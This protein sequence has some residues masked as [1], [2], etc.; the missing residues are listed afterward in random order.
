MDII[1]LRKDKRRTDPVRG[2][3]YLL[4]TG[5][6][7]VFVGG[8]L[9]GRFVAE[10]KGPLGF[11]YTLH[12]VNG[13]GS[14]TCSKEVP[15][16]I[17]P[18]FNHGKTTR[19]VY[20]TATSDKLYLLRLKSGVTP[21]P[22][23]E[24]LKGVVRVALQDGALRDPAAVAEDA[25]KAA[26]ARRAKDNTAKVEKDAEF[27]TKAKECLGQLQAYIGAP[28]EAPAEDVA[29][30]VELMKWAQSR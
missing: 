15:S 16:D 23:N 20:Y 29:L 30:V 24:R 2:Q 25:K 11:L 7:D 17:N 22:L 4:N 5:G 3:S 8:V 12:Q 13:T 18:R 26:E 14:R 1:E 28:G 9:W 10:S 19:S 21:V 6:F 27:S